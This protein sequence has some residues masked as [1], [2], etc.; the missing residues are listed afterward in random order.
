VPS[1]FFLSFWFPA[2]CSFPADI[3]KTQIGLEQDLRTRGSPC[4]LTDDLT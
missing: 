1:L 3:V 4:S 2:I